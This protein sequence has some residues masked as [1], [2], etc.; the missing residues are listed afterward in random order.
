MF[1]RSVWVEGVLLCLVKRFICVWCYWL[2]VN[3]SA[4]LGTLCV[5]CSVVE[6][7]DGGS[8]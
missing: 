8:G 5:V 7:D 1:I 2:L 6:F 4:L 3:V